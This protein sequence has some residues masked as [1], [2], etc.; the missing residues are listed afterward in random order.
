MNKEVVKELIQDELTPDNITRELRLILQDTATQQ[1]IMA[2]YASLKSTL[3][4]GGAA[5]SNAARIVY[6]FTKSNPRQ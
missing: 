2:D 4:Q 1:Q 5:S 6:N 3:Q